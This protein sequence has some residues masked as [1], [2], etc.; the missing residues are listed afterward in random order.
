[1]DASGRETLPALKLL[2]ISCP[3]VFGN[4]RPQDKVWPQDNSGP[5]T[6]PALKQVRPKS[7][8]PRNFCPFSASPS[9]SFFSKQQTCPDLSW[10]RTCIRA[11]LLSGPEMSQGRSCLKVCGHTC[12]GP[13]VSKSLGPEM[14]RSRTWSSTG[15]VFELWVNHSSEMFLFDFHYR[16]VAL[17]YAILADQ[18]TLSQT[19]GTEFRPSDSADSH[20]TLALFLSLIFLELIFQQNPCPQNFTIGVMLCC[21]PISISGYLDLL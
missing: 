17:G 2:D 8:A 16:P 20:Q 6:T 3:K 13:E 14:S 4:V 7:L 1:M 11:G 5:K 12:L 18:S 10:G 15:S 19:R 21:I 9:Q